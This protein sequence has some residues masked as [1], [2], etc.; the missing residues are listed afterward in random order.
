MCVFIYH[1]SL[2]VK[3]TTTW[4]SNLSNKIKG[5]IFPA[6][7]VS[8]LVYSC[9]AWTQAK[10]LERNLDRNYTGML[11]AVFKQRL[12]TALYE[13]AAGQ[14]LSSH[15]VKHPSKLEKRCWKTKNE[16]INTWTHQYRQK[17]NSST[18]YGP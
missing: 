13:I 11:P 12:E 16:R 6:G 14:P 17:K 8:V 1:A 3:L 9:T 15:F 4:K 10:R 5:D 2:V 18:F 7:T